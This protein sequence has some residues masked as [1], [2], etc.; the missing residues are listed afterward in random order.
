MIAAKKLSFSMLMYCLLGMANAQQKAM[1]VLQ[2]SQITA[3]VDTT[4]Q[5][6]I[7]V[8]LYFN[9]YESLTKQG[10]LRKVNALDSSR[11]MQTPNDEKVRFSVYVNLVENEMRSRQ[12]ASTELIIVK[13]TLEKINWDI[14]PTFRTIGSLRCQMA[15]GWVR[16]RTY[17]AWFAP[18]IPLPFGPWKLQGL[19]GL[20][21]EARS[22]DNAVFFR[23]ESL[24]LPVGEQDNLFL[25]PIAP[26]GKVKIVN[27]QKFL[28]IKGQHE[29]NFQKML[30]SQPGAEKTD[31]VTSTGI[32]VF[33]ERK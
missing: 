17:M 28:E 23:F 7:P 6:L 33:P 30:E 4:K 2:Y 14:S 22:L 24:Q 9:K 12:R 1:G 5:N 16:G 25:E 21:I 20:I 8:S 10:L 32:E 29:Y 19:P 26:F 11:V 13:D 3:F 15:K 27:E 31:K 18:D